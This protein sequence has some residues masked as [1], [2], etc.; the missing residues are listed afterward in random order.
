M[1]SAVN[2]AQKLKRQRDRIR[3]QKATGAKPIKTKLPE[4]LQEFIPALSPK[5]KSPT[6][7]TNITNLLDQIKVLNAKQREEALERGEEVPEPVK[8][9]FTLPPQHQKTQ[10]VLHFMAKLLGENQKLN[11]L[12]LTYNQTKANI[13]A[14]K[15]QGYAVK[16]GVIP[17]P[18]MQNL[19]TWMTL[20]DGGLYCR[21]LDSG[22]TGVPADVV[23]ID[24]LFKGRRDYLS[25]ETRDKAWEILQEAY[26]DRTHEGSSVIM[27][28]TRWGNDDAIAR[29]RKN[30]M[31]FQ[32]I[33]IPALADHLDFDGQNLAP[34]M[35]YPP[36]ELGEALLPQQTSRESLEAMRDNPA[37]SW[38]FTTVNQGIPRDDSTKIFKDAVYY[39]TAPTDGLRRGFGMDAA[40]TSK[41]KND[42][43]VL[44]EAL[45]H[46]ETDI[47]Y[48][49]NCYAQHMTPETWFPEVKARAHNYQILWK[50]SGVELG[51]AN[52]A[53]TNYGL[54]LNFQVTPH[55]KV[56]NATAV[57][58]RWNE[59]KV[60]IKAGA[61]WV[62]DLLN[63]VLEF[64]GDPGM[65]DDIVDA[66]GNADEQARQGGSMN[67]G[68]AG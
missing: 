44:I 9:A 32:F 18:R 57:A 49:E 11:I 41:K 47:T 21:G 28:F 38:R 29:A 56:A 59:G 64:T 33:R 14:L 67:L 37:T 60:R 22:I 63:E 10:T 4:T 62:T 13:E 27:F 31:Q 34:D 2:Y 36:R 24:D 61:P 65:N 35:A 16:A 46:P 66:L 12:Y 52:L 30:N 23:V 20:E 25:K 7:L 17:D 26:Y 1:N 43:S 58:T 48:I 51:T 42:R 54:N 19:A 8:L 39:T 50:G 6:H 5:F 53:K 55:D 68:W 15:V 45:Y 3:E 40:Y